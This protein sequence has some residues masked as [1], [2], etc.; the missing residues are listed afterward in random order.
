MRGKELGGG[1]DIFRRDLLVFL[2]PL[3]DLILLLGDVELV[4]PADHLHILTDIRRHRFACIGEDGVAREQV[5]GHQQFGEIGNALKHE[6]HR[7]MPVIAD[8][9]DQQPVR[10]GLWIL[11]GGFAVKQG[12][13]PLPGQLVHHAFINM[14]HLGLSQNL[15]LELPLGRRNHPDSGIAVHIHK[16]QGTK[17]VK[18]DISYLFD[19]LLLTVSLDLYFQLLHRLWMLAPFRAFLAQHEIQLVGHLLDQVAAGV[20]GEFF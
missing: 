18:P 6:W 13:D 7:T 17:A 11:A 4:E 3:E 15:R 1:G 19:H 2:Q 16:T 20:L 12:E 14:A 8:R 9:H 10:L 5:V